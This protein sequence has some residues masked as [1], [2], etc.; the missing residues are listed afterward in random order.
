VDEDQAIGQTL[1]GEPRQKEE[2]VK[3]SKKKKGEG[4][5][6][7]YQ[8]PEV[9]GSKAREKKKEKRNTSGGGGRKL[10]LEAWDK[11]LAFCR[12]KDR[13]CCMGERRSCGKQELT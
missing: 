3:H 9:E 4:G 7:W 8:G 11:N 6:N 10:A 1:K 12:E 2:K 5:G 13:G